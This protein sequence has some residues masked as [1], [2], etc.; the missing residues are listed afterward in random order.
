MKGGT[1]GRKERGRGRKGGRSREAIF[2]KGVQIPLSRRHGACAPL[3]GQG[4][5]ARRRQT[6]VRGRR[7]EGGAGK[8]Q[9][10]ALASG[11]RDA[12]RGGGRR[13]GKAGKEG[14]LGGR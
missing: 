13:Q 7:G 3:H 10:Q 11:G 2:Q 9:G 5:K 6:A 8:G 12:G 1:E 14:D 4:G